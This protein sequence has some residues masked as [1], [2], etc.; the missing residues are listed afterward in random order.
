M[1]RLTLR[2]KFNMNIAFAFKPKQFG[3]AYLSLLIV[4]FF[5]SLAA[6]A[7]LQVNSLMAQRAAEDELIDI[8]LQFKAALRSYANASLPHMNTYPSSLDE[9]VKDTRFPVLKRHL[10]KVPI[11][12]MIKQARWGLVHAKD[13]GIVGIFSLSEK[14]AIKVASF[15]EDL[16]KLEG[17]AFYREWIFD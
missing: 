5:L 4:L 7:T 1:E 8:G 12:P 13:G 14:K 9:L 15:P 2:Y 3:M 11:D 16:S 6:T 17:T 10:R